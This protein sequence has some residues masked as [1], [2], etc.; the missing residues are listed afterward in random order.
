MDK[1]LVNDIRAIIMILFLS[2]SVFLV[3]KSAVLDTLKM[4]YSIYRWT[5]T[6]YKELVRLSVCIIS[7]T[8]AIDCFDDA[9]RIATVGS[10]FSNW[11]ET[12]I[13]PQ[14]IY[15]HIVIILSCLVLAADLGIF[16]FKM[17]NTE[18][19]WPDKVILAETVILLLVPFLLVGSHCIGKLILYPIRQFSKEDAYSR[20]SLFCAGL[21][22]ISIL[23]LVCIA[24]FSKKGF[25]FSC[26]DVK[27]DGKAPVT[28]WGSPNEKMEKESPEVKIKYWFMVKI[29]LKRH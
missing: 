22:L 23:F 18:T 27:K 8:M 17:Y 29:F 28:I 4:L 7:C 26:L 3:I 19:G 16:L 21:F 9:Q 20:S 11:L 14:M 10:S 24:Y 2:M 15:H 25:D 12:G 6:R 1:V 13:L 5:D